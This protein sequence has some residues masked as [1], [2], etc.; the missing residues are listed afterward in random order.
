MT[1]DKTMRILLILPFFYPHRGGSQKYAEELFAAMMKNHTNLKVDV[2]C[3]NT[4]KTKI[5]E[6]YRG[7]TIYRI[8]CVNIIPARFALANPIALITKLKQLSS[9]RYDYI[10]TH[11]RFF[12][13]T[14]WVWA[15]AKLSGAKS[16]FTGHVATHPVHQ[17]KVVEWISKLTDLTIARF[18][19]GFYD[20]VT[21]TNKAAENFFRTNLGFKKPSYLI[22]GGVDTS[23][24]SPSSKV[25]RVLPK[26]NIPVADEQ[27]LVT[28]V[29]RLIWTKGVTYL[30]EA[31]RNIVNM[32][33]FTKAV[34]VLAGP[35]ELEEQLKNR[36]QKEALAS[37]VIL[38]G[39]LSYDQVKSLLGMSDVFV[40]P[41]HH[42]EGFPNTVLEAGSA[43]CFVIA[44]DNA[45]TREVI[46]NGETGTLIP[47]KHVNSIQESIEWA[48]LHPAERQKIAGN[49]REE[50]VEKF[51]W[52][53]ISE[54]LYKVLK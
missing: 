37:K 26:V 48:L 3:Y 52:D 15:Y 44:S 8:P 12:D 23:F 4:D 21:F 27:V 7:F 41:S 9:N 43:G 51:D 11:I 35:G 31:I 47:Q 2:L 20:Y 45:G 10:N 40:N 54:Q 32:G 5:Y 19:L 6:E 39:N 14:W 33:K 49:F 46:R 25:N 30:Y 36:I 16:I 50:L 17:N 29:G 34:F 24:F 13:P 53:N 22:Y 42:N 18:S 1:T 38:T 28:F